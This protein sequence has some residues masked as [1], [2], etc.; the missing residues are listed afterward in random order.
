M[1]LVFLWPFSAAVY[2]VFSPF[3]FLLFPVPPRNTEL[4]EILFTLD[5]DEV[6]GN[7]EESYLVISEKG[8]VD[9]PFDKFAETFSIKQNPRWHHLEHHFG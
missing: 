9:Q 5:T 7:M 1:L 4:E 8:I 6:D 3:P 2:S